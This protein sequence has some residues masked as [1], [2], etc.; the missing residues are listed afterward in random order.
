MNHRAR[1]NGDESTDRAISAVVQR[2]SAI[3]GTPAPA[4]Q[5]ITMVGPSLI[6]VWLLL[7]KCSLTVFNLNFED[8]RWKTDVGCLC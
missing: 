8:E 5:A 4:V 1:R 7:G 6:S 3:G 2:A